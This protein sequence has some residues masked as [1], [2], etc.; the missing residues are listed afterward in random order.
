MR[1]EKKKENNPVNCKIHY[2]Y[3]GWPL[4]NLLILWR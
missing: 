1:G 4:L 3:E 2:N